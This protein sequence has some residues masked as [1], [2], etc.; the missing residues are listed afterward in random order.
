MKLKITIFDFPKYS[1]KLSIDL[2]PTHHFDLIAFFALKAE[3]LHR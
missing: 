1:N 2:N 3:K